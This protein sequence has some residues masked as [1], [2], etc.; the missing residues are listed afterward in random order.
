MIAIVQNQ[1]P[2]KVFETLDSPNRE[3]NFKVEVNS[4]FGWAIA[5]IHRSL[6][7]ELE[8]DF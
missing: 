5:E 7:K 3:V 8:N 4:S 6:L 2:S 1:L